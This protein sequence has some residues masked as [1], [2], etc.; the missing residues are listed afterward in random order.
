MRIVVVYFQTPH[1]RIIKPIAFKPIITPQNRFTPQRPSPPQKPSPPS[2]V[3]P[4]QYPASHHSPPTGHHSVNPMSPNH[5]PP[6]RSDPAL[7]LANHSHDDGYMSQDGIHNNSGTL[8]FHGTIHGS[9]QALDTTLDHSTHSSSQDGHSQHNGYPYK[10]SDTQSYAS[11]NLSRVSS[12]MGG[13]VYNMGTPSP[14]DSGVGEIEAVLRSKDA[15]I[16]NLR[17]TMEKNESAILQVCVVM[18]T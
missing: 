4:S 13:D 8:N 16:R 12:N 5:A 7:R 11:S 18:E 15:E 14:S 1:E 6:D 10:T 17:E 9:M 3:R 2:G